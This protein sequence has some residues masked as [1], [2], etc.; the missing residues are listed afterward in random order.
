M[1]CASQAVHRY[2]ATTHFS[3]IPTFILSCLAGDHEAAVIFQVIFDRG[4]LHEKI[5]LA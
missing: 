1:K 2:E 3:C 4:N 5:T